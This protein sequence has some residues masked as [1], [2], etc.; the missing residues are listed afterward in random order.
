MDFPVITIEKPIRVRG[1][2]VVDASINYGKAS[3]RVRITLTDRLAANLMKMRA[4]IRIAGDEEDLVI[5]GLFDRIVSTGKAILANPAVRFAVNQIP[6]G[7]QALTV[8]DAGF[9]VA[10]AVRS[11]TKTAEAVKKQPP[12]LQQVVNKHG[13]ALALVRDAR[14]KKP[15]ALQMMRAL[16]PNAAELVRSAQ[17]YEARTDAM[18]D[19]KLAAEGDAKALDRI[20]RARAAKNTNPFAQSYFEALENIAVS[21]QVPNELPYA[22]PGDFQAPEVGAKVKRPKVRRPPVIVITELQHIIHRNA[23]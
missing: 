14:A 22:A 7:N 20:V 13:A 23:A 18:R 11:S 19:F 21:E 2:W 5:A 12:A 4:G 15:A 8:A 1:G 3:D 10:D 16:P 9:A 17:F 6:Y